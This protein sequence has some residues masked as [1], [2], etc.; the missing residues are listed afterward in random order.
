MF[1]A[2]SLQSPYPLPPLFTPVQQHTSPSPPR[3]WKRHSTEWISKGSVV[4]ESEVWIGPEGNRPILTVRTVRQFVPLLGKY[5]VVPLFFTTRGLGPTPASAKSTVG[6]RRYAVVP[7][8]AYHFGYPNHGARI[9]QKNTKSG[10][11]RY[12]SRRLSIL[13]IIVPLQSHK[14]G[15]EVSD[16]ALEDQRDHNSREQLT[17]S[18]Y[19]ELSSSASGNIAG[20]SSGVGII[21]VSVPRLVIRQQPPLSRTTD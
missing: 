11:R 12:A 1:E 13:L 18:F 5:N 10:T 3:V 17:N 15:S 21:S 16:R 20:A 9:K 2:P 14:I 4:E 6:M 7:T 19:N 8:H